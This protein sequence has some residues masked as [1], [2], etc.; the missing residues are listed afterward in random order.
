MDSSTLAASPFPE[1][2]TQ[3]W[4]T[5]IGGSMT[6]FCTFGVVQSF[7][8]YQDVY[9]R[10]LLNE[11]SPSTISWI[12]STQVFFLFAIGLP[13]S[14][15]FDAGYFRHCLAFGS[16][17]LIF[18]M[19][20][21][22]LAQPHHFYQF[23]LAQGVGMGIGMGCLFLPSLTVVS[24]Y[25][26]RRRSVAM[27]LVIAGN[28]G[29][30][31]YPVMLNNLFGRSWGFAVRAVAYLDLGLL[32]I[33][34][35]IMR[36][37]LP[38]RSQKGQADSLI[39]EVLHDVNFMIYVL[40]TF[41]VFWGVFVPFFYL[42]LYTNLNGQVPALL[43]KYSI[44]IM[45]AASIFGRTLP[46]FAADAYGPVNVL[47]LCSI[48]SAG[49]IFAMFGAVTTPGVLGFAITY[50]FFSGGA[51]S[52]AAPAAACFSSRKDLSDLGMRLGVL[53]FT[54]GSALLTGS[55][56]A[57]ALLEAPEYHW[58]RP[59]IFGSVSVL[60]GSACYLVIWKNLAT[61]RSTK[62]V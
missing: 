38:P 60:A 47:I 3:A 5:V 19:F 1:G 2:G 26:R 15:L 23:F 50:G 30:C 48:C 44:T 43:T 18:S 49:I 51:V 22:S 21:L 20:M 54:L 4:L 58:H 27:G 56:I 59:I 42:Q 57:G 46:N 41:L 52:L 13:A 55:P 24:E 36:K 35:F 45:N 53:S 31:L 39:G 11:H 7:G 40:G 33:A 6:T 17:M 32:I 14:R 29:G 9:T 37:R 16:C 12:G 8:V 28:L 25:F 34:N 62:F 61:R 10:V